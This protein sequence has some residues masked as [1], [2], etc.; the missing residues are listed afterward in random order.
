M[1]STST[2]GGAPI[3]AVTTIPLGPGI[4]LMIMRSERGYCFSS[5]SRH[6][7]APLPLLAR[8]H[9]DRVFPDLEAAVDF[10]RDLLPTLS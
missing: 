1:S 10:F 7:D 4:S 8:E 3:S 6:D 9:R 5:W 2:C